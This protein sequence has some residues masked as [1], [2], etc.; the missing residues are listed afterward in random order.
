[1]TSSI[2]CNSAVQTATSILFLSLVLS[3]RRPVLM[4]EALLM[5]LLTRLRSDSLTSDLAWYNSFSRTHRGLYLLYLVSAKIVR[6][7][8]CLHILMLSCWCYFS[9]YLPKIS[10]AIIIFSLLVGHG[11][12]SNSSPSR[13]RKC[14]RDGGLAEQYNFHHNFQIIYEGKPSFPFPCYG[15]SYICLP[16]RTILIRDS[17]SR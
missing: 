6:E 3:F 15:T 5:S 10:L 2:F 17:A 11:S 16:K 4:R 13:H 12:P 1:M 7:V 9:G 8:S 14:I